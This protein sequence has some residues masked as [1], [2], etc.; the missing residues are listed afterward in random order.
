MAD[1]P[2]GERQLEILRDFH[3]P[4]SPLVRRRLLQALQ[5]AQE[6][7]D[8]RAALTFGRD[9]LGPSRDLARLEANEEN[10][11]ALRAVGRGLLRRAEGA[12]ALDVLQRAASMAEL[13]ARPAEERGADLVELAE[14]LRAQDELGRA[15]SRCRDALALLDLQPVAPALEQRACLL[16]AE[17]AALAGDL[18]PALEL[19]ARGRALGPLGPLQGV[20]QVLALGQLWRSLA[21]AGDLAQALQAAEVARELLA[22]AAAHETQ[23]PGPASERLADHL[24]ALG[25][26]RRRA[27]DLEGA[28]VAW[29]QALGILQMVKGP[30]DPAVAA[31]LNNLGALAWDAGEEEQGLRLV[32]QANRIFSETYGL[33]HPHTQASGQALKRMREHLEEQQ[34][35]ARFA[36]TRAAHAEDEGAQS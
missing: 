14:A 26:L 5:A 20:G 30:T 1:D 35:Q 22:E 3:G 21:E 11:G 32:R 15:R 34:D 16:G 9:L 8:W 17:L 12:E 31:L 28:R 13:L 6:A 2:Y 33:S 23:V 25:A 29:S 4:D 7:Q 27:E 19:L 36:Q 18:G 24:F 10:L